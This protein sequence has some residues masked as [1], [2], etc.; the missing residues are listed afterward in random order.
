[1]D[2]L[3]QL[4][5][6]NALEIEKLDLIELI[7]A[8]HILKYDTRWRIVRWAVVRSPKS[9]QTLYERKYL[10]LDTDT[11]FKIVHILL[12]FDTDYVKRTLSIAFP[13]I[14]FGYEV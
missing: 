2:A 1:M 13:R 11:I 6:D 14:V 3:V 5:L 10:E 9:S 8:S 12:E 7:Q 4:D